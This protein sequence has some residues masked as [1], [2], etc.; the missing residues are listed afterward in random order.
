MT[1]LTQYE[2][3]DTEFFSVRDTMGVPHPYTIGTKHVTHAADYHSG[4]IGE[5]TCKAI[6]C[7]MKGCQLSYKEHET[8]L[9]INCKT[10]DH[11]LLKAY[12]TTI[13]DQCEK[14]KYAGFVLIDCT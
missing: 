12:L 11:D 6:P 3:F 13:G 10:K 4:R 8:A 1:D 14:D 5:E 9:A 7:A 2:Q